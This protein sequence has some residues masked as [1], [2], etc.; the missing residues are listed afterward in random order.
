M[1]VRRVF[2]FVTFHS[3]KI[4]FNLERSVRQQT[5]QVGFCRNFYRHQVDNDNF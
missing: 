4:N 5:D 1:L 2:R 3:Q